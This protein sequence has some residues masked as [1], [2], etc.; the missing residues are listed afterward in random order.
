MKDI[1]TK[2]SNTFYNFYQIEIILNEE[3]I[4]KNVSYIANNKLVYLYPKLTQI[5]QEMCYLPYDMDDSLNDRI[6]HLSPVLNLQVT[7]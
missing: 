6:N 4:C 5:I 2:G 1:I 7:I 3:I